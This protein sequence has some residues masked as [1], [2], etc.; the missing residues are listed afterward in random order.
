MPL[1]ASNRSG[2]G[3]SR[4]APRYLLSGEQVVTH[5]QEASIVP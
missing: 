4:G 2:K 1:S 5:A 3:L